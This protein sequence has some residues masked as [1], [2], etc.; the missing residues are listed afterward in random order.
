MNCPALDPDSARIL[1]GVAETLVVIA[2]VAELVL[3]LAGV[4][5]SVVVIA[6]VAVLE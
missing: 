6:M 1:A 5:V 4:A 3:I 2:I